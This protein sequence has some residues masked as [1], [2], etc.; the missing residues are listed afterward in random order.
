MDTS[1]SWFLWRADGVEIML[2][3]AK[4]PRLV[5]RDIVLGIRG[6]G[7]WFWL[8]PSPALWHWASLF[9]SLGLSF[10]TYKMTQWRIFKGPSRP[11]KLWHSW[12][13]F[14][15]LTSGT[16]LYILGCCEDQVQSE[17]S[18]LAQ[19]YGGKPWNSIYHHL[20]WGRLRVEA[21]AQMSC[22]IVKEK[23]TTF[24]SG[25][26]KPRRSPRVACTLR[27]VSEARSPSLFLPVRW[28]FISQP[29]CLRALP[30]LGCEQRSKWG[31]KERGGRK[32]GGG[33]GRGEE[34]LLS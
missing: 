32:G 7:G 29:S 1:A 8:C 10:L 34:S 22:E 18:S 24:Q 6:P 15:H 2:K 23:W 28:I 19:V 4:H 20:H 31:G 12:S 27:W 33:R 9:F 5:H 14:S 3:S 21:G 11:P 13:L 30:A 17:R 16:T 25:S 26:L